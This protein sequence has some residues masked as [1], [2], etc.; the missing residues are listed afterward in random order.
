MS[1]TNAI[2]QG[3]D[4]GELLRSLQEI[5]TETSELTKENE[6]NKR[7]IQEK[8]TEL[9]ELSARRQQLERESSQKLELLV[10]THTGLRQ[11]PDLMVSCFFFRISVQNIY[12]ISRTNS[13]SSRPSRLYWSRGCKRRTKRWQDSRRSNLMT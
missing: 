11:I 1:D 2:N 4:W 12:P 7:I 13:R 3:A 8:E 5:M 10:Q 6:V 9:A